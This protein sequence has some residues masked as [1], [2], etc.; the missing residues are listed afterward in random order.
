M[1]VLSGAM[2]WLPVCPV[3]D[4]VGGGGLGGA[5]GELPEARTLSDSLENVAALAALLP[6]LVSGSG[7]RPRILPPIPTGLP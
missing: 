6:D 4:G 5:Y 1:A 2:A 3:P 7:R